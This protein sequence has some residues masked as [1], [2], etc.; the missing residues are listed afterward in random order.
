[1][2]WPDLPRCKPLIQCELESYLRNRL[3]VT[4]NRRPLLTTVVEISPQ[5]H[6]LS[7]NVWCL[8]FSNDIPKHDIVN[9]IYGIPD[10]EWIQYLLQMWLSSTFWNS[11]S[12]LKTSIINTE[13]MNAQET[14]V[15]SQKQ[16]RLIPTWI[17]HGGSSRW[18]EQRNRGV[19]W[20]IHSVFIRYKK[21]R[22]G[23]YSQLTRI[24]HSSSIKS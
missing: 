12:F 19:H 14:A 1:M 11:C 10:T 13:W 15:K 9:L 4:P 5:H 6:H 17:L 2:L 16:T 8:W 22:R 7:G 3:H 23:N 21:L 24:L 18:R 20:L